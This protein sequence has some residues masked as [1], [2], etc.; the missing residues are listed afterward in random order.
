MDEWSQV[1]PQRLQ[2]QPG[3]GDT[4]LLSLE[5]PRPGGDEWGQISAEGTADAS[6]KPLEDRATPVAALR[7]R[8]CCVSEPGAD[9]L[10]QQVNKCVPSS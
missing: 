5:V 7:S 6:S 4:S 8:E 1:H 10:A 2:V 9:R 3:M